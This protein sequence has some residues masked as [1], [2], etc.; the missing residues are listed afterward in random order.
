MDA[1]DVPCHV[2]GVWPV[3]AHSPAEE[4]LQVSGAA[5]EPVTQLLQKFLFTQ[6]INNRRNALRQTKESK[7]GHGGQLLGLCPYEPP[8]DQH[9]QHEVHKIG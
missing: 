7:D 8:V 2:L 1:W 6:T 4:T 5:G 9:S 3:G